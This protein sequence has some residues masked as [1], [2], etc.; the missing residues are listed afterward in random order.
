VA[1]NPLIC[2]TEGIVGILGRGAL[3]LHSLV[4]QDLARQLSLL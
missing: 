1:I 4:Q 2:E 3:Q